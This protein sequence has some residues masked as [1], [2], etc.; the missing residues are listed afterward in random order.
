MRKVP[1]FNIRHILIAVAA[2]ALLFAVGEFDKRDN[3]CTPLAPVL[4][5]V[6]LCGAVAAWGARARGRT[7]RAG[8]WAG[9]L[10]GPLGVIWAWSNPIPERFKE[11]RGRAGTIAS[12]PDASSRDS[13]Q[14]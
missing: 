10:L 13:F 4:L 5:V 1:Q 2:T 8:L 14:P 3:Q 12:H 11:P 9:L 6:Y 7:A